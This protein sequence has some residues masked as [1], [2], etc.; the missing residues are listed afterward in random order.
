MS[1][2]NRQA[3]IAR[4]IN[5]FCY[6]SKAQ[7]IATGGCDKTI[8]LFNPFL[9]N[10]PTSKLTGH[11]FTIVDIVCNEKDQQLISLSSE[12]VFKVWDL[13]T[14]KCLQVIIKNALI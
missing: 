5:T 12:R 4:G 6:C 10:K 3:S 7:L 9:L 11:L 2:I 13:F 8:R 1:R 14:Y